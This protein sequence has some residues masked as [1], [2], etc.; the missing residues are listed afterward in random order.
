MQRYT[1]HF[2]RP[3]VTVR[4]D[5]MF[6]DKIV[7]DSNTSEQ[8]VVV[9]SGGAPTLG[10]RRDELF[11]DYEEEGGSQSSQSSAASDISET[12]MSPKEATE[13]YFIRMFTLA[14]LISSSNAGAKA[15]V[16]GSKRVQKLFEKMTA[17]RGKES[18][19]SKSPVWATSARKAPDLVLRYAAI[20]AI[21]KWAAQWLGLGS[22]PVLDSSSSSSSS[23][24]AATPSYQQL[25]AKQLECLDLYLKNGFEFDT[26]VREDSFP[27]S[28]FCIPVIGK[29]EVRL[30]SMYVVKM[31]LV[32]GPCWLY[33]VSVGGGVGV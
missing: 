18:Q 15:V 13:Q 31:V 33:G 8:Q 16:P 19:A 26:D 4:R 20:L 23:A 1:V 5:G 10:V 32:F 17:M 12:G 6:A 25:S 7:V 9:A 21:M 3:D 14:A 24:S 30:Q 11:H 2:A 27:P 22:V 29:H 28:L